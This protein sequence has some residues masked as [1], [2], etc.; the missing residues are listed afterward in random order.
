MRWTIMLSHGWSRDC[1]SWARNPRRRILGLKKMTPMTIRGKARLGNQ[2]FN[3]LRIQGGR[4]A[5]SPGSGISF[6]GDYQAAFAFLMRGA[7]Q[8]ALRTRVFGLVCPAKNALGS[9]SSSCPGGPTFRSFFPSRTPIF[10]IFS[11]SVISRGI[12]VVFEAPRTSNVHVWG[13]RAVV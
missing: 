8:G 9:C 13:S 5:H 10:A 11:L 12:W 7:F 3:I 2:K 6:R 1:G 4:A